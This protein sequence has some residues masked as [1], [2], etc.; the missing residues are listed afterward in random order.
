MIAHRPQLSITFGP[1]RALV[2][3][4]GE[5]VRYLVAE[6]SATGTVLQ[7]RERVP[8]NLALAIDVSGSMAGE[9]LE[10]AR[11]TAVAVAESLYPG[12]RLT[13]VA[14]SDRAEL[15]LDACPMD[16]AGCTIAIAAIRELRTRS[17]TNL[18]GG[19]DLAVGHVAAAM[20]AQPRAS[21]RVLLIT[22]GRAN[23]GIHDT[24]SLAR[25][26]GDAFRDGII[27]SAV[28]IGDDYDEGLLSAI[29]E[30]GGGRVHDATTGPEI[31]DVILGELL[32]GRTA[33]VE[34]GILRIEIPLH[35]TKV[36]VVGPWSSEERAGVVSVLVGSLHP[37]QVRRVVPRV[38]CLGGPAG[39][40]FDFDASVHA[41]LPDG[42]AELRADP[43]RLILTYADGDTNAAQPRHIERSLVALKAWQG[44]AMRHAMELNRAGRRQQARDYLGTE[45]RW[46]TRYA[47][48]LPGAAQVLRELELLDAQVDEEMDSRVVKEVMLM[49]SKSLRGE[50]DLR[51]RKA[52]GAEELLR[53][54]PR[55]S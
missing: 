2:W 8:V 30:A 26:A 1:D 41:Q 18:H 29:T 5:S 3:S 49:Q 51:S 4:K 34:R 16:T 35:A 11:A 17:S 45:L 44:V 14:F 19:W 10:A 31:Y 40:Y 47:Q 12:D 6:I 42:S 38:F 54:R 27:T 28:G 15:L 23:V 36:E 9:K 32:E 48:G 46:I 7:D 20:A 43:E 39:G 25:F 33:L 55:R 37:D 50:R 21:H 22:D 52:S 53:R 24:P 13:V